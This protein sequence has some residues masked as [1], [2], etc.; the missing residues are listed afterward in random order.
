M[1]PIQAAQHSLMNEMAQRDEPPCN[2]MD[3]AAL[4]V[5]RGE[6]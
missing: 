2:A 3:S 1:M 5:G 4:L 6:V